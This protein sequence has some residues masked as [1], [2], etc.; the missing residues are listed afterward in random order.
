MINLS[1]TVTGNQGNVNYNWSMV[2]TQGAAQTGLNL[3]FLNNNAT[4]T[5]P[6]GLTWLGANATSGTYEFTVLVIGVDQKQCSLNKV[7]KLYFDPICQLVVNSI[8]IS[9]IV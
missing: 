5:F 2:Q 9:N 3:T 1:V 6:S 4:I 8:T 7:Q